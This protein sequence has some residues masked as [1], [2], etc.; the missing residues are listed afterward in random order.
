[1]TSLPVAKRGVALGYIE[2]LIA[3]GELDAGWTIQEVVDRYVRPTT[4]AARCVTHT[5][6]KFHAA[7]LIL[8]SHSMHNQ[9]PKKCVAN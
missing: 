4:A 9:K 6:C 8:Y 3:L 1:M 2:Q 7:A 5:R